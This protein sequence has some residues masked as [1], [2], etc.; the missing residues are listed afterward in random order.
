M[1]S[2]HAVLPITNVALG[3]SQPLRT[4]GLSASELRDF[5]RDGFVILR[6]VVSPAE[7]ARLPL[8]FVSLA[9]TWLCFARCARLL[10]ERIVP[11]LTAAGIDPFE[12]STW[13]EGTS[14]TLLSTLSTAV[15]TSVSTAVSTSVSTSVYTSVYT[16]VLKRDNL[17]SM[18]DILGSEG[19]VI[20]ARG[21]GD[22][23]IPLTCPDG[24]WPAIFDSAALIAALDELHGGSDGWRWAYGELLTLF[25][26]LAC[27]SDC[28]LARRVFGL[29]P[30]VVF[31]I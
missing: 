12:D 25:S 28:L 6:S 2:T 31:N 14:D 30:R 5:Q 20:K 7:C 10:W 29:G 3:V 18:N 21:G 11:A 17:A 27:A 16:S 23:P 13:G 1:P 15:S 4:G 26:L 22:H 8:V 9:K 24:R 19:T